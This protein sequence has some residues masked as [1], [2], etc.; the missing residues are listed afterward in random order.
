M[1]ENELAAKL[2]QAVDQL[3][4]KQKM[5]F[6][7]RDMEGLEVPEVCQLVSLN[8]DQVKSNLYYARKKVQEWMKKNYY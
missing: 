6:V 8:E 5:I 3:D 7:L 4:G 1:E 2:Q